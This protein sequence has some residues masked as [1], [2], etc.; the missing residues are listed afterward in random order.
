MC[1]LQVTCGHRARGPDV[2]I[3]IV[4]RHGTGQPGSTVAVVDSTVLECV[5]GDY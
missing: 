1:L 3:Q 5:C 4:C 2:E